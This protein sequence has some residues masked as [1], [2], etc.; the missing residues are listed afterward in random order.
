MVYTVGDVTCKV[1]KYIQYYAPE[2]ACGP[3]VGYP[4][5]LIVTESAP[6]HVGAPDVGAMQ[7]I[8][9]FAALRR[10]NEWCSEY[11]FSGTEKSSV[12]SSTQ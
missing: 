10:G 3:D 4:S 6:F 1:Y 12:K 2:V 5:P 7:G 11:I 9:P 8:M